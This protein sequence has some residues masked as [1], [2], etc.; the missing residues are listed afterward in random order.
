MSDPN[1]AHVLVEEAF[2]LA[3]QKLE[4]DAAERYPYA[5]GLA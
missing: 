1:P 2:E 5:E 4:Q 3:H